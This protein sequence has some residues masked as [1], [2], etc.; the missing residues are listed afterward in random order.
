MLDKGKSR[1][2]VIHCYFKNITERFFTKMLQVPETVQ[3]GRPSVVLSVPVHKV[4]KPAHLEAL[5]SFSATPAGASGNYWVH[6]STAAMEYKA[7][8]DMR[9]AELIIMP[10]I[11]S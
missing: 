10:L 9:L 1:S 4:L 7:L 5:R 11:D 2:N 6:L 3:S 8:Q